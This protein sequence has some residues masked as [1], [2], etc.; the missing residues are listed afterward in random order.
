MLQTQVFQ[1]FTQRPSRGV[2]KFGAYLLF[3]GSSYGV[4]WHQSQKA[5]LDRRNAAVTRTIEE[6]KPKELNGPDL[7]QYP[8]ARDDSL[9]KWEFQLVKMLGY[10][11][12]PKIS[13][14]R[15]RSGSSS[16]GS[17]RAR[18]AT[19]CWPRSS[20][21]RRPPTPIPSRR[22]SAPRRSWS[23]WAGCPS[24]TRTTSSS[25]PSPLER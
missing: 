21:P 18:M 15:R 16:S 17:A 23:T 25:A 19:W 24:S 3:A 6:W 9:D 14:S 1:S 10:F 11:R 12:V 7:V 2:L 8:W 4:Y 20:L 13:H 5:V 22:A